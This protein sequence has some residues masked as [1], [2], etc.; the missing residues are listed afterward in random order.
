[1]NNK[2]IDLDGLTRYDENL[3]DY[4]SSLPV[5]GK[6][7]EASSAKPFDFDDSSNIGIYYPSYIN[8]SRKFYYKKD[9][10]HNAYVSMHQELSFMMIK[11]LSKAVNNE[12][13]GYYF[14][15]D[16][17]DNIRLYIFKKDDAGGVETGFAIFGSL[18]NN[19][20][21]T[22]SGAK[23]FS[24]LP[25]SSVVP[26]TDEHLVN[27]KY[28]DDSMYLANTYSTTE[29]KIGSYLGNDLYRIVITLTG[30]EYD[31]LSAVGSTSSKEYPVS[32]LNIDS[33]IRGDVKIKQTETSTNTV[34]CKTFPMHRMTSGDN[35][36]CGIAKYD[37]AGYLNLYVGSGARSNLSGDIEIIL[38]YT[39]NTLNS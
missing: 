23:T 27:K 22:I 11:T 21:Q 19:S 14:Y 37:S 36:D 16:D 35:Y 4:I 1:M 25:K 6:A 17:S 26:T 7:P 2:L 5:V 12:I 9:S 24:S 32:S 18:L 3:K 28:V 29:T 31:N 39:K 34:S 33:L 15:I 20:T 10:S 8:S 13:L 30:T 38:E